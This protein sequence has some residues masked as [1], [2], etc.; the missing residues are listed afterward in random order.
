MAH[1]INLM[2]AIVQDREFHECERGHNLRCGKGSFLRA[3]HAHGFVQASV[4]AWRWS[5]LIESASQ[6][7]GGTALL[8]GRRGRLSQDPA[9][10]QPSVASP[11]ARPDARCSQMSRDSARL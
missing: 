5:R 11:L 2:A 1:V 4:T 10:G 3:L 8:E 9:V 7:R 6:V